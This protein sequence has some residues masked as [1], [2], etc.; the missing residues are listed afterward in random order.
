MGK[1]YSGFDKQKALENYTQAAVL[2]KRV[3]A[4]RKFPRAVYT[5]YRRKEAEVLSSLGALTFNPADPNRSL[6]YY[7]LAITIYEEL[8]G[9]TALKNTLKAIGKLYEDAGDRAA[10]G[11]YYR[12]AEGYKLPEETGPSEKEP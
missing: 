1:L 10:A 8:R 4:S 5:N 7:E 9:D 11:E 12:K 2:Y 3:I 6:R